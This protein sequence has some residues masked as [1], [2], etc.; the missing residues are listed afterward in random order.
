[1]EDVNKRAND[2]F[3]GK[4]LG[5]DAKKEAGG[6]KREMLVRQNVLGGLL[7]RLSA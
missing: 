3:E 4:H 5:D 1:M 2:S 6:R 7:P